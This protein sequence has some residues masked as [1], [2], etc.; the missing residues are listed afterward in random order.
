[1][2]KESK[3]Q[4]EKASRA[5]AQEEDAWVTDDGDSAWESDYGPPIYDHLGYELCHKKIAMSNMMP[6]KPT[7]KDEIRERILDREKERKRVIMGT[8]QN[9]ISALTLMA[10]N[11][12]VADCL[13][14]PYHMVTMDD[15]EEIHRMGLK[16][17][18]EKFVASN[19]SKEETDAITKRAQGSGL[20]KS[21]MVSRDHGPPRTRPGGVESGGSGGMRQYSQRI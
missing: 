2:K 16:F 4:S 11:G 9:D 21:C 18:P 6:R 8:P 7:W 20:R 5:K 1:M 19:W 13:N 12:T 15:Y 17:P 10:W 3:S 14:K